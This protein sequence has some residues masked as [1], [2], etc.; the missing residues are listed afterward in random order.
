MSKR[1]LSDKDRKA[2]LAKYKEDKLNDAPANISDKVLI[3]NY[4]TDEQKALLATPTPKTG[5]ATTNQTP[6]ANNGNGNPPASTTTQ[7][8]ANN[9]GNDSGKIGAEKER[10]HQVAEYQRLYGV[11]PSEDLSTSEITAY[12]VTKINEIAAA[13]RNNPQSQE[14]LDALNRYIELNGGQAPTTQLTLDALIEANEQKALELQAGNTQ[15]STTTQAIA[16]DLKAG[17]FEGKPLP[18][19]TATTTNKD[20]DKIECIHKDGRKKKFTQFTYDQFIS[21]D[22]DWERVPQAPKEVQGLE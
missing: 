20:V 17:T 14:Y 15:A 21:K 7:D 4:G 22:K 19:V 6:T 8:P 13:E 11:A 5:A 18:N 10:E 2:L 1:I 9:E 3:E 16:N 12:N